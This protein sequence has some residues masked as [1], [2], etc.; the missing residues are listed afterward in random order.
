MLQHIDTL[1]NRHF[2]KNIEEIETE[3]KNVMKVVVSK[4]DSAI[5]VS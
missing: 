1:Y 4:L 3:R 5:L 2:Q